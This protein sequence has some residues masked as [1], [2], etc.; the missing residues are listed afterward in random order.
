MLRYIAQDDEAHSIGDKFLDDLSGNTR[1]Q[2]EKIVSEAFDGNDNKIGLMAACLA[3]QIDS[4][5][6]GSHGPAIR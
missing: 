4:V 3:N 1:S 5:L 2:P 6:A